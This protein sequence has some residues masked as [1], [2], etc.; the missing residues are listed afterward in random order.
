[1]TIF[2]IK[3]VVNVDIY[4]LLQIV[5]CSKSTIK[6]LDWYVLNAVLNV[7][8]VNNKGI[9]VTSID[10]ILISFNL[11]LIQYKVFNNIKSR[12]IMNVHHI[13]LLFLLLPLSKWWSVKYCICWKSVKYLINGTASCIMKFRS[14]TFNSG[15]FWS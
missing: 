6:T 10:D 12:K 8:K 3:Y 9:I 14:K 15:Q 5:T 2:I 4:S 13:N 1:M 11:E 7:L